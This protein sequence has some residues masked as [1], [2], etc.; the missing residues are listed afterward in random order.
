MERIEL[1]E[2]YLESSLTNLGVPLSESV[3]EKRESW[4]KI[5]YVYIF[6]ITFFIK[7]VN[8]YLIYLS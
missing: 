6:I 3:Q 2:F 4:P 8:L 7:H 1:I 5:S